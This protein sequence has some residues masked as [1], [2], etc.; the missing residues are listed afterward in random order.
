MRVII[1]SPIRLTGEINKVTW[2]ISTSEDG[3]NYMGDP[4]PTEMFGCRWK[5][6][7]TKGTCGS[8]IANKELKYWHE[9]RYDD[10]DV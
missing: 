4:R 9:G 1:K 10:A 3:K 6:K 5:F 7:R 8:A 2:F